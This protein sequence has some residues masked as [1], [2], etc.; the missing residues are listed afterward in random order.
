M[1][2]KKKVE[3]LEKELSKI[4]MKIYEL[5]VGGRRLHP[6]HPYVLVRV[7]PKEH[8]TEGG[9]WLAETSQNKPCYESIV[10]AVW[11]PYDEIRWEEKL[12]PNGDTIQERVVIHHEC[13]LKVGDRVVHPHYEGIALGDYLDDRYYRLI[14]EGADQNQW[15]YMSVLG[16]IDYQGDDTVASKIRELTKQVGSITTSGV[17]VARGS[18]R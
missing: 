8:K 14:R 3:K 2:N 9:I 17:S 13:A 4:C 7:L 10:I 12:L 16:K 15:P 18:D 6:R 1:K 5:A 11:E